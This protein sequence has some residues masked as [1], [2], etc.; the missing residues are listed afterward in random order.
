M[1]AAELS[2]EYFTGQAEF[3]EWLAA[4]HASSP[5]IWLKMA[6]KGSAHSSIDYDRALEVALCYG[7]IDSQVRRVDDDFFVQRF[8][9]RSARSPWSKRNR[10]FAEKLA[11]GGLLEPAGVAEVERARA[12]GRW[13]RAYAG[14]KGAEI[15][16]DF[17][18]A[19]ARNPEAEAFYATLDSHNRYAVYYRLQD[20]KRPET[21]ARRIE[22]FVQQLADRRKFHD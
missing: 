12:D 21:R 20:A 5:G 15:P 17:L 11:E 7:W 16:Q 6:K 1:G 4:H 13:D 9:P 14:Q 10:E 18:D 19:L 8:T 2:V 3:R 22:K